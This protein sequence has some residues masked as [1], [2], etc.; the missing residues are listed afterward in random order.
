MSIVQFIV[1]L[2]SHCLLLQVSTNGLISFGTAYTNYDVRT[3]PIEVPVVAPYWA[4][5]H[6]ANGRVVYRIADETL[7]GNINTFISSR[8][9]TIFAGSFAL[10]VRWDRVCPYSG[11]LI[12]NCN[13]VSN[14]RYQLH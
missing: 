7:L 12:V 4:D 9:G 8:E 14:I 1:Q 10:V 13:N 11:D 5:I 6:T 2:H 3:F